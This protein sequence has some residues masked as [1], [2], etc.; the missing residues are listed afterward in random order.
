MTCAAAITPRHQQKKRPPG[1]TRRATMSRS[2]ANLQDQWAVS[3]TQ[4]CGFTGSADLTR[5]TPA[6]TTPRLW[7]AIPIPAPAAATTGGEHPDS[8]K[9]AASARARFRRSQPKRQVE[10]WLAPPRPAPSPGRPSGAP[11]QAPSRS[12]SRFLPHPEV[13]RAQSRQG[14]VHARMEE[15]PGA[16]RAGSPASSTPRSAANRDCPAGRGRRD[17]AADCRDQ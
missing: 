4:T 17:N 8:S 3:A 7:A 10:A 11:R 6:S 13:R 9:S 15:G 5:P 12:R 14:A 2:K 16:G 1:M